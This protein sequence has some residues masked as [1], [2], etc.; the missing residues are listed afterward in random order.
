MAAIAEVATEA[1][2][3][4]AATGTAPAGAPLPLALRLFLVTALLVGL[5]VGAAVLVT[6]LV[7][8]R[9]AREAVMAALDD[10][11]AA[12]RSLGA[13]R[14]DLLERTIQLA[15]SDA[16]LTTYVAVAFGGDL[17]LGG[18]PVTDAASIRDL[19]LERRSQWGFDLGLVLDTEGAVIARTDELEAF[20]DSL[21]DDPLVAPALAELSP[22]SGFWRHQDLL[23]QAAIVPLTQGTALVGYL[24][25][26]QRVDDAL[27]QDIAR[28]S[29][30]QVAFWLPGTEQAPRLV[31]SS[32]SESQAAL[33]A[34]HVAATP[35]LVD[36]LQ[37]GQPVDRLALRVGGEDWL[38]RATPMSTGDGALGSATALASATAAARGYRQILDLV[39]LAGSGSLLLALLLSLWL[40]RRIL[41]PVDRLA[42]A[43]ERAAAG[44]YHASTAMAGKDALARLGRALDS[45]LS[46]LREKRDTEGYMATFSRFLP[47]PQEAG[48]AIATPAPQPLPA[49][50]RADCVLLALELPVDA[51][52]GEQAALE[53]LGE[54]A[55]Q[56]QELA[57]LCRG[58]IAAADGERWLLAFDGD[59]RLERALQ[60]ARVAQA[61]LGS[62]E[63][64]P[65]LA[66]AEGDTV[67][68]GLL[69]GPRPHSAVLGT[70]A[71]QLLRLLCESAPGRALLARPL[72]EQVRQRFGTE[73][74]EVATGILAG[75]RYY[76]LR[77]AGLAG[78]AEPEPVADATAETQAATQAARPARRDRDELRPG[79]RIGDRYE[80]LSVLG[81]GGMGI[82]YKA[83]D[84]DLADVVALKMLRPGALADSEQ[85]ERLKDEIRLARRITHPNV[86]R[87]FDF[88]ELGGRPYIS[89][90]YVRGVTLRALLDQSG[91]LPYS[92]G[93]RIARQLCAGLGAAH[94]VGVLHRDIK[95]ENLILEAGGNARLMDFGIARPSRRERP[96]PTQ[97]G[98]FVGTPHY[99]APEQLA[100][101]EV[102][103]RADIYAC[104]ALM[105]EM[106]CGGLP[107]AGRTTMEI[108]LAQ[109]QQE[110]VRPSALWPE[111][112]P[113]LERL[114]LRCIA[115]RREDR[116]QTAAEL[117]AALAELRA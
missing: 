69:V 113:P 83:R 31:A 19:L 98:M 40:S 11:A 41:R 16:D 7:G 1:P 115:R 39:L 117:G 85:L 87:T 97:P 108:Y 106:F 65:A 55:A 3:P 52:R 71:R 92:A 104:G 57:R 112:P 61:E 82:V 84:L 10:S 28:G 60:A 99:S 109:V 29:D 68:A 6:W 80:I 116:F 43:A 66:L 70:P 25:L 54:T 59:D 93:L 96:G 64:R 94:E 47:D 105:S 26:A 107:Y 14:L 30:A 76:A 34:E 110:P 45:L 73:A 5:A 101:E 90:E 67:E 27:S 100:G 102:D 38:V 63:L 32:L 21:A 17:G 111:I 2:V 9:I 56:V 72:G 89:M 37:L 78:L 15:A 33:L 114:I 79:E 53:V 77:A 35:A 88:G 18:A 49:P 36:A 8:E 81:A 103:E 44:D 22:V 20:S 50:R 4:G 58:R 23:Y 62:A 24:L 75:R 74:L 13:Q 46:D 42:D 95:P 91:R 86:L 48:P 51:G 12:Q